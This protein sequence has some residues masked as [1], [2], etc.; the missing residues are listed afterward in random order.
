MKWI[1]VAG[2]GRLQGLPE[3]QVW[4]SRAVG[5]LLA[6]EGYGLVGG[7]WHGVD[8]VVA[9]AFAQEL[10]RLDRRLSTSLLQVVPEGGGPQF[11]GG[12]VTRVRR[13]LDEFTRTIE[14][15][16]AGI[17]IGGEGATYKVYRTCVQ[18][19]IPVFPVA[20][21]GGDAARAFADIE[22]TWDLQPAALRAVQDQFSLL[23]QAIPDEASAGRVAEQ[24]MP[25][26]RRAL[27]H[28]APAPATPK[29]SIQ[30]FDVFLSHNSV[31]KPAVEELDQ[32]LRGR[33]LTTWFDR[34]Q[35]V[36]GQRWQDDLEEI[37]LTARTAAIIIGQHGM[38]PWQEL[39]RRA[40]LQESVRRGLPL[41]PVL[42]P[43][44]PAPNE[45]SPF[46]QLFMAVDL[47]SGL[48]PE[49]LERLVRGIRY[50]ADPPAA[51]PP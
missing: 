51:A 40:L 35:L 49:G 46:L 2:T 9:D 23:S 36:A 15:V 38:G 4:V 29:M 33:E 32:A 8:Y 6:R 50:P 11:P 41:I 7:G 1:V 16:E 37:I 27:D 42:L 26:L 17:L 14:N 10:R 12:R 5:R 39:E 45:L 30:R 34:E 13:G 21:T 24:L 22:E 19:R 44:A 47:R 31:D 43:G 20:G 28:P 3:T 48:S 18:E 25:L